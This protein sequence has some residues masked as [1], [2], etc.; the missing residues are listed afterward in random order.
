MGF[1]EGMFP[2]SRS[3][4]YTGMFHFLAYQAITC[5]N[6]ENK[7][8]LNSRCRENCGAKRRITGVL[9]LA[10]RCLDRCKTRLGKAKFRWSLVSINDDTG[11]M[12]LYTELDN[13]TINGI[14]YC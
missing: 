2:S 4:A 1:T 10:A 6:D 14:L 13:M 7:K 9:A 11:D 8:F 12:E 5:A 3:I